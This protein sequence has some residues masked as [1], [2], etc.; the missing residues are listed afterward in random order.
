MYSLN[1]RHCAGRGPLTARRGGGAGP[2]AGAGPERGRRRKLRIG[3]FVPLSGPAGIWGPAALK[4]ADLAVRE[5]NARHGIL[6][7]EVELTIFDAGGAP[8]E[9]AALAAD[10]VGLDEIDVIVGGHLS[11]VRVAMRNAIAGQVP[12]IFTSIYEGG[13]RT[14]GVLAIGETPPRQLRPAINWLVEE[15]RARRWYLIGSDYLWPWLSHRAVKQYIFDAGGHVVG[16]DFVPLGEDEHDG[17][18]DRIEAASPDVVL[19]SMIGNESIV[20]NRAFAE[21][22][23]ARRVLRLGDAMDETVLLGIGA[24]NTENIFAASGYFVSVRTAANDAFRE[25]YYGAFGLHAPVP[26]APAQSSYEGLH[27]LTALV[28]RAQ[29]LELWPLVSAAE[30][31]TYSAGRG[32][33]NVRGHEAEM[34]MYLAEADGYDFRP[35]KL[36]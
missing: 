16:E 1:V 34:P 36:L 4:I 8:D 30:R 14:P 15:K 24:E 2:F 25:R 20:F 17:Y 21:R 19:I 27:F 11:P 35:F 31:M 26:G 28:E 10:A 32:P 29:T 9:V 3:Y 7:R 18:L 6:G 12:Y 13:E 5:I 22:G 33:V 23:L